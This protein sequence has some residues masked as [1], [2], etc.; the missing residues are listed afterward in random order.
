MHLQRTNT[1]KSNQTRKN[2]RN[3]YN[4]QLKLLLNNNP[5]IE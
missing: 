4:I 5:I 3:K 2:I 1:L